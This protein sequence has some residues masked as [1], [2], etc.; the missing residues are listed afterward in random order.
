[1]YNN[2][3]KIVNLNV[4]NDIWIDLGE[5]LKSI[6]VHFGTNKKDLKLSSQYPSLSIN[7]KKF[8]SLITGESKLCE[9]TLPLF[10]FHN[11]M[12]KLTQLVKLL[13]RYFWLQR[14]FNIVICIYNY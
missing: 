9:S 4:G 10:Y 13:H 2:F 3:A 7:V 1:M 12:N 14:F 6:T 8:E 5:E 11:G